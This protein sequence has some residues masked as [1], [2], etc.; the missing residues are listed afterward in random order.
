MFRV[1][2]SQVV[3]MFLLLPIFVLRMLL[4]VRTVILIVLLVCT[5]REMRDR[6]IPAVIRVLSPDYIILDVVYR[7]L[8]GL[9]S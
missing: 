6:T 4:P 1:L 5:I 8:F 3:I 2:C 7:L 9:V